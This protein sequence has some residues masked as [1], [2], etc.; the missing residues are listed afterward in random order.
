MQS[1]QSPEF[2]DPPPVPEIP[3]HIVVL[4]LEA[5]QRFIGKLQDVLGEEDPARRLHFVQKI[6]AVLDELHRRLNHDQ[7]GELVANLVRMYDWWRR[8]VLAASHQ[9]DANRLHRVHAQMGD[10]RQAW[11]QVLFKGEGM[12]GNPQF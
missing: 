7:G 5:A 4:L 12:S 11:E 6:E 3:E 10:I 9:G 1:P 8:E 2:I